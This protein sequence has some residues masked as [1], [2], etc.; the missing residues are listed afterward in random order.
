MKKKKIIKFAAIMIIVV[1]ILI[2]IVMVCKNLLY[3]NENNRLDGIE[4]HKLTKKE[5]SSAK[6]KLNTLENIDSIDIYTND[7]TKK[8]VLF[9][10]ITDDIDFEKVKQVSNDTISSF[11][12]DNLAFY[13]LE[14][15]FDTKKE[16]SEVYPQ[17]GYK[18][19]SSEGFSW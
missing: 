11:T 16:D 14:I 5:I 13:D 18:F 8:I 12:E 2:A 6:E 19:K 9:V 3:S 10:T 17:I 15:Y 4:N 7:K 1:I